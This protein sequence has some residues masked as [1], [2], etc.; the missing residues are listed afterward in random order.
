MV[1]VFCCISGTTIVVDHIHCFYNLNYCKHIDF[2]IFCKGVPFER[3]RLFYLV[4]CF[5]LHTPYSRG[6]CIYID[7]LLHGV[8]QCS[9]ILHTHISFRNVQIIKILSLFILAVAINA[10]G[11]M[12]VNLNSLSPLYYLFLEYIATYVVEYLRYRFW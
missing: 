2:H 12:K 1:H 8:S 11:E 6:M 3:R 9:Y 4:T 10:F 7:G 5:H